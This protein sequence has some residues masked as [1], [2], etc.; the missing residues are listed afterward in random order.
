MGAVGAGGPAGAVDRGSPA[1][2]P[3]PTPQVLHLAFGDLDLH[4]FERQGGLPVIFGS[5]LSVILSKTVTD[6]APPQRRPES[7]EPDR[8]DP[9]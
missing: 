6:P 1:G 2:L 7:A 3:Q 8:I 4:R 5:G 9:L